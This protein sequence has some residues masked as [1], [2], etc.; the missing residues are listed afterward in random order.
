M[1]DLANDAKRLLDLISKAGDDDEYLP[2]D[3]LRYKTPPA[4]LTPMPLS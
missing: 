4:G 3:K 1:E 2:W